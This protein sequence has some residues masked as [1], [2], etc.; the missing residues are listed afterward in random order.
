MKHPILFLASCLAAISFAVPARATDYYAAA[1]GSQ[2]AAGTLAAPFSVFKA[3]S[4]A[5][6]GDTVY[7]RGGTYSGSLTPQNSGTA[8]AWITFAAYPGELPIFDG[9]GAGGTGIGSSTAQYVR[10]VGLVARNYSSGGFANGWTGSTCS[11]MSNGNLQFVNCIADGNGINGIA[12][13]CA[14]NL[15]IDESI[16]LHNG[17]TPPSWS[18]GV[19]LFHVYGDYTT[20]IV[21]RTVSFENVDV[22][23]QASCTAPTGK[24][25]DGSGF[26]LDQNSTGALFANNIGF[27]NGG[28]CIRLTN[29]AGAHLVN[30]TC[31]H[32]GLSPADAQSQPTK[33]GEIYFSDSAS[34]N[35]AVFFNNLAAA[36]GYNNDQTA[37]AGLVPSGQTNFS[38]NSNAAT[39]FFSDAAGDH[40]DFHLTSSAQTNIIDKG[41]ATNAP[42]TDIGFDPKC[43]SRASGA[44][45]GAP[46][47]WQYQVDYAYITSIGGVAACFKPN[48]RSATPDIGAYEFTSATPACTSAAQCDDSDVC[49]TDACSAGA[50]SHSAVAACCKTAAD[51]NDGNACTTDSCSAATGVCGHASVAGCCLSA[52]DC[53]DTNPCTTDTCNTTSHVCGHSTVSGCCQ[54]DSACNDGNAC[55]ADTCNLTTHQCATQAISSCCNQDTDCGTTSSCVQTTCNVST[56]ACVSAVI[57]S[58]CTSNASCDDQNPCTADTCNTSSGACTNTALS[59]CCQ[60]DG[61]CADQ[62]PCTTDRC[63]L[64]NHSCSHTANPSCCTLDA[65]C[66]DNDSCTLD[67]C[68]LSNNACAHTADPACNAAG[69][70]GANA[71]G[72]NAGGASAGGA[73]AGGASAG[74]AS[75]A[76][77]TDAGGTS[78]GGAA[79]SAFNAGG[80]GSAGASSAGASGSP[81]A[82]VGGFVASAG[83]PTLG[84]AGANAVAGGGV[85]GAAA[86]PVGPTTSESGATGGSGPGCACSV[87]SEQR[88]A[89]W[90]ALMGLS[91]GVFVGLRRRVRRWPT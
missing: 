58:C 72:A 6:A 66:G 39:P 89:P 2:S 73:S 68:N 71:G 70:G 43:L 87:P 86:V 69:A 36:S 35:G 26:I 31:Y 51:C 8:S 27:R 10:F 33:P 12:F 11:T 13:Y 63:N 40:P 30:N 29:S 16:V 91:L 81:S 38:V 85:G 48:A 75:S 21:Q 1:N 82:G 41:T 77:T 53:N 42:A 76:G 60:L 74:G 44:I 65:Q 24:S 83:A 3:A 52:S 59:A 34:K 90:G 37:F 84:G 80:A 67:S 88:K 49:T 19:N 7:L 55:T 18:S 61:D 45:A 54:Q 17:N 23:G 46:T 20:N 62:D 22:C 4:I 32:D 5:K 56:H 28:S 15:L 50:C 64:A 79:G 14:S 25:S 57:P 9:K 47:F 78:S